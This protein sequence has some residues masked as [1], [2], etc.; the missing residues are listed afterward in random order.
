M[1]RADSSTGQG[2]GKATP[3]VRL[4]DRLAGRVPP[5]PPA[6]VDEAAPYRTALERLGPDAMGHWLE[7]AYHEGV[8]GTAAMIRRAAELAGVV[9]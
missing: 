3:A 2:A 7:A 6:E 1:D 5:S 8:T 9:P 4:R